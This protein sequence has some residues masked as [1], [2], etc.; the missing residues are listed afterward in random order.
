MR[1]R[2]LGRDWDGAVVPIMTEEQIA[3]ILTKGLHKAKSEK[4]QKTLGMV[5]KATLEGSLPWGG[6]S[7]RVQDK[8]LECSSQRKNG[9]FSIE[10]SRISNK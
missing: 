8:F 6:V 10:H 7:R 4:F 2:Y 3:N 1:K 5:C 9:I